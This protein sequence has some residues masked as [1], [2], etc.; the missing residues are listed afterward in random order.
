MRIPNL[1]DFAISDSLECNFQEGKNLGEE[2]HPFIALDKT[3]LD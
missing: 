1:L 3:G 2:R